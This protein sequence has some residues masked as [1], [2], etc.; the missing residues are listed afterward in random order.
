MVTGWRQAQLD[1]HLVSSYAVIWNASA[2]SVQPRNTGA[3]L[4]GEWRCSTYGRSWLQRAGP[5]CNVH[6]GG[7]DE[8]EAVTSPDMAGSG[9][10][11]PRA[12]HEPAVP[13]GLLLAKP[14]EKA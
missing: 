1:G 4:D 9:T 5:C 14:P 10:M 6:A 3:V 13:S 12:D 8:T 2:T 7:I 11:C